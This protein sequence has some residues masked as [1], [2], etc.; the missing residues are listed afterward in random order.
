VDC[1]KEKR[2]QLKAIEMDYCRM[3][4]LLTEQDRVRNE[5][6]RRRGQVDTDIIKTI[7]AKRLLWY[8]D[9]QRTPEER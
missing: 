3:G 5:K 6:I 7:E 8:A 1:I 4:C 9:L 2:R